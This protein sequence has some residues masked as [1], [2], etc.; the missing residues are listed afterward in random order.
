MDERP[1]QW[2]DY[3]GIGNALYSLEE[4]LAKYEVNT[5]LLR[6]NLHSKMLATASVSALWQRTYADEVFVVFEQR[7]D[8]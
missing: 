3:I 5:L 8:T 7:G 4:L 2:Q 1:E 6:S